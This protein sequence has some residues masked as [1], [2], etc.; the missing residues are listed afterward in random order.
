ME[1]RIAP[2]ASPPAAATSTLSATS[3]ASAVSWSMLAGLATTGLG[4][5]TSVM[6]AR[7]LGPREMGEYSYWKWLL[8]ALPAAIGLGIPVAT[9]KFSA[10]LLGRAQLERAS[11]LVTGL[12]KAQVSVLVAAAAVVVAIGALAGGGDRWLTHAVAAAI[13]LLG[14]VVPVLDAA[15]KGAIDYR[16]P[17]RVTVVVGVVQIAVA[18]GVLAGGGG[19]VGLLLA[20]AL[21]SVI[22]S[23]LRIHRLREI[24]R[25]DW[26]ARFPRDLRRPV[27]RYCRALALMTVLDVVVMSRSEVFVLKLYAPP[28]EIAFYSLA[29]GMA[30]ALIMGA[31][32]ITHPL[33]PTFSM[34]AGQSDWAAIGRVYTVGLKGVAFVIFPSA[35][36]GIA[37]ARPLVGLL[38]SEAYVPAAPVL[39]VVTVSSIATG[40]AFVFSALLYGVGAPAV[41][42]GLFLV[43]AP[44]NVLASLALVPGYGALGAAWAN[45]IG[46]L[47]QLIVLAGLLRWRFRLRF[48][49]RALA[50]LTAAAVGGALAAAALGSGGRPAVWFV[51]AAAAGLGIYLA[52][53]RVL[54]VFDE[55]DGQVFSQ[56]GHSLPRAAR[57]LYGRALR[58][59]T[60]TGD[61]SA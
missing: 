1:R 4:L 28:E 38:Y 14:G 11:A 29:Y 21:S 42:L 31:T 44:V 45:A 18:A 7:A 22:A 36:A 54:R 27:F 57:P 37:L 16:V 2:R 59:M 40:L 12:L 39:A 32:L 43:L 23:S 49:L 20:L 13:L 60:G 3:V 33:L 50:K 52:G 15:L 41:L 55:G 48:P 46:P 10:E 24:Y 6:I 8:G 9:L 5:A 51:P 25:P 26:R 58:W 34:L 56:V 35:I 53:V 30:S 61:P 19:I 17:A 47:V